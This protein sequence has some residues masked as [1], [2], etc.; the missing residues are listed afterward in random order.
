MDDVDTEDSIR[1]HDVSAVS[2]WC[3]DI[4]SAYVCPI[5]EV[6]P[7]LESLDVTFSKWEGSKITGFCVRT[8]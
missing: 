3:I 4:E 1:K 8:G 6:F 2:A 7:T 5:C